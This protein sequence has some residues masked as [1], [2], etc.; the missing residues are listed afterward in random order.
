MR[1]VYGLNESFAVIDEMPIF[2]SRIMRT[3][4][5]YIPSLIRLHNDQQ[6]GQIIRLMNIRSV[7]RNSQFL[8]DE[9]A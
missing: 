9:R 2:M 6:N 5:K 1:A 3:R 8:L 7:E 4:S